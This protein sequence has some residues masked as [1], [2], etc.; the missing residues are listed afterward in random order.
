MALTVSNTSQTLDLLK[1]LNS[2]TSNLNRVNDALASG[3]RINRASDDP[4][5]NAI[6]T[7]LF[8]QSSVDVVAAR[9]I[10][11]GVSIANI[12][13]GALSSAS[14]ITV[15]LNE[16]AT[17]AS[18]GTLS[19]TQRTA[20]NQ[21]FSALRSQLDTISNTTEFNG[22]QLLS[23]NGTSIA[24]Q[25]G[26]DAS[27]NSQINLQTTGVSSQ[28]LGLA[29]LDISTQAGAQAAL[30]STK[31]AVSALSQTRGDLGAVVSRLDTAFDQIQTDRLGRS[32]A[33]SRISDA[34][35]ASEASKST[36]YKI[37]QQVATSLLAQANSASAAVLKLIS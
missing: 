11:D 27:S 13:E 36:A 12:A 24:L 15:R 31:N 14:D 34:D 29:S 17:Q 35:I 26:G 37:S 28:S 4:A 25:V 18:N 9:N 5:G 30:D 33:A 32:E 3:K 7:Q 10:S 16:L 6:A 20:L 22:Q 1:N 8:A 19:D 23:G 2:A 21:E